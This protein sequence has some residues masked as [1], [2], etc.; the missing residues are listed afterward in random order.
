MPS[1]L[2]I[3]NVEMFLLD[4]EDELPSPVKG[5]G[6]G[7]GGGAR[8]E[9]IREEDGEYLDG[10]WNVIFWHVF[11]TVTVNGINLACVR[12]SVNCLRQQSGSDLPAVVPG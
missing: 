1:R 12:I 2:N 6:W 7:R 4:C 10:G 3:Q 8:G 11:Y 9:N 5:R